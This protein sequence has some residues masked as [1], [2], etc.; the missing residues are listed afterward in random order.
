MSYTIDVYRG[1]VNAQKICWTFVAYVTLFPQPDCRSHRPL[2]EHCRR[3]GT[4]RSHAGS[5]CGRHTPL[6]LRSR[7]KILLANNIGLLWEVASAQAAPT[8]L[9]AWLGAITYGFQIYFDFSGYSDMA[10]GLR[11]HAGLPLPGKL[12]LSVYRGQHHRFLEVLAYLR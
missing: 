9:T 8:M 10:I 2:S 5:V 12:Q 11:P 1:E 6:R 7:Q 3:T 4:P